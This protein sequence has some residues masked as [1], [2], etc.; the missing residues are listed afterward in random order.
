M[1]KF[2]L[3]VINLVNIILVSIAFGL[4]ANTAVT[5]TDNYTAR[6]NYY[7]LIWERSF[8]PVAIFGFFLFIFAVALVLVNFLPLKVRKFVT[9]LT[10]A[11]FIATGVIF[12]RT[13]YLS[14]S[15]TN[16]EVT[17]SLIAMAVLVFVAGALSLLMSVIEFL[18]AKESK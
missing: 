2:L 4:G 16:G 13:P 1:R 14:I 10:G 12:L 7:Q 15:M 18:P 8:N 5:G 17:G 3:P 11:A 6:G 9:L